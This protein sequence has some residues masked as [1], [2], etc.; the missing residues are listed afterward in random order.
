MRH[1]VPVL[2]LYGRSISYACVGP[3]LHN[4]SQIYDEHVIP[5]NHVKPISITVLQLKAPR[6]SSLFL[7]QRIVIAE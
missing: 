6:A 3:H 1:A 2:R 4:F 7:T 5:G